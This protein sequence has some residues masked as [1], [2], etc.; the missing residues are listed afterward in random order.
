M[1]HRITKPNRTRAAKTAK[2]TLGSNK[3]S[4][5]GQLIDR[6]RTYSPDEPLET[7]NHELLQAMLR[8]LRTILQKP[9]SVRNLEKIC[10]INGCYLDNEICRHFPYWEKDPTTFWEPLAEALPAYSSLPGKEER[11]RAFFSHALVL[12]VDLQIRRIQWRFVTIMAHRHFER[13]HPIA[14]LKTEKVRD[15]LL[16]IGL[17]ATERNVLRCHNIITSGKRRKEFCQKFQAISVEQTQA[18]R[19]ENQ[20]SVNYGLMFM[21]CIPDDLYV[22]YFIL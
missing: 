8:T 9:R 22:C 11:L 15:Y 1:P 2:G 10:A 14:N 3:I 7:V 20:Y 12:E 5:V 13:R 21:D 6:L 17:E 16:E 18:Q 4:N 19:E